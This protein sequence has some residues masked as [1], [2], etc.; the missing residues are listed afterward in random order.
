MAA[1]PRT[2]SMA[3]PVL[4]EDAGASRRLIYALQECLR[5]ALGAIRAHGLR[6]F[7]TMLG[8]IIG[9]A[10]VI[11]VI[12]LVQGMSSSISQQF[13]GLGSSTLTLRAETPVEDQLRGQMNRL[14]LTDVDELRYRIDGISDITPMVPVPAGSVTYGSRSASGQF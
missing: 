11:C 8:V 7:L 6:S 12:A 9:V 14:R 3:E 5:S 13:Q 2:G 10:S 4:V 1:S